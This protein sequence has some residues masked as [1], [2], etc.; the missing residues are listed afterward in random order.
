MASGE[1]GQEVTEG[2]RGAGSD[3]RRERGQEVLW[4]T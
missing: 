1:R 2:G 3:R 4:K